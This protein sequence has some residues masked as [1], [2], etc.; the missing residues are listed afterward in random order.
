MS[1]GVDVVEVARIA[2]L[3]AGR[4]GFVER[5]FSPAEVADAVRD[6]VEVT[7]P[8]AATRLAARFAGKEAT[9]KALAL[10]TTP[11]RDIEVLANRSAP[12]V[13]VGGVPAPVALALAHDAGVAIAFAVST[14]TQ[15][16]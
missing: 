13:T 4:A 6:G 7:S 12:R 10:T 1:V 14:T 3:V 9:R 15:E 2:R 8:V 11:W 16:G 5:V